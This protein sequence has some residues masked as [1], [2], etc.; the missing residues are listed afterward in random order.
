MTVQFHF[1][2]FPALE[3]ARLSLRALT[4]EDVPALRAIFG[5]PDVIRY[6]ADTETPI[7]DE[8][9]LRGI[10]DWSRRI[11]ASRTGLRWGITLRGE[12]GVIGTC[13]FHLLDAHNQ[14]A[15]VG[16]DL[17]HAYWRR[18]IMSEALAAVV[19]F[20]FDR[21]NLHR[22]AANVTEGN[23]ASV[24]TLLKA[25]FQQEGIWRER[26]YLRGKFYDL[27]QFGLL[28]SEFEQRTTSNLDN[29]VLG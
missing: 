9:E 20:G 19:G 26:A 24:K 10:V 8:D 29:S 22:I 3:T 23:E 11:F 28:R 13:G 6:M 12:A 4:D 18:G 1:T 15:E 7:T 17:A 2:S 25:G 16:Y 21:L 27:L 5:D 14:H